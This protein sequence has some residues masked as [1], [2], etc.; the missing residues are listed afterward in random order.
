MSFNQVWSGSAI[1]PSASLIVWGETEHL[2]VV[3]TSFHKG[4]ILATR[5]ASKI[6]YLAADKNKS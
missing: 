1:A 3:Q 5:E 6:N 2:M 4:V